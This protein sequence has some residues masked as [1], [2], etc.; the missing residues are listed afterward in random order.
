MTLTVRHA[1]IGRNKSNYRRS[2]QQSTSQAALMSF[3]G[4]D[5]QTGD[6][7][8]PTDQNAISRSRKPMRD[9]IGEVS[10]VDK[11]K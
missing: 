5:G 9:S 8:L 3:C 2:H 4:D 1:D 6:N 11:L 7:K 10:E